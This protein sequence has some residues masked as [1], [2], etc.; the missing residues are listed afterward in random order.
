MSAD[1]TET[2]EVDGVT[3]TLTSRKVNRSELPPAVLGAIDGGNWFKRHPD[4]TG[5]QAAIAAGEAHW[6]AI[7][8]S[9]CKADDVVEYTQAFLRACVAGDP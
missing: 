1:K 5:L 9:E 8:K 4:C 2:R 3:Y 6:K 7:D